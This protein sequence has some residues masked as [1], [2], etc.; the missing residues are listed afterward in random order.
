MMRLRR[1]LRGSE[2]FPVMHYREATK[3]L[4]RTNESHPA[5]AHGSVVVDGRAGGRGVVVGGGGSDQRPLGL[6]LGAVGVVVFDDVVLPAEE[7]D[8]GWRRQKEV[9]HVDGNTLGL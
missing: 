7:G 5:A 3:T 1:L 8:D 6:L 2:T 9:R 4:R